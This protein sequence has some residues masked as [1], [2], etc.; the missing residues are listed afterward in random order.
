MEGKE[1]L[2]MLMEKTLE[3]FEMFGCLVPSAYEYRV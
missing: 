2:E 1:T 3:L